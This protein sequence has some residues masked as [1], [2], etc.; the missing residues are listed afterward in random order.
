MGIHRVKGGN[1]ALLEIEY[2]RLTGPL[3]LAQLT[4]IVINCILLIDVK[5][6]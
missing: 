6:I 2:D 5:N 3:S 1:V 4:S